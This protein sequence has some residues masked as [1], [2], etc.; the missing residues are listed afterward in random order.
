MHGIREDIALNTYTEHTGH[1]WDYSNTPSNL[2]SVGYVKLLAQ[3][4][5]YHL[6]WHLVKEVDKCN[7]L[8][9]ESVKT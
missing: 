5:L 6:N 4:L 2:R 9:T 8:L 1:L 3:P 7:L